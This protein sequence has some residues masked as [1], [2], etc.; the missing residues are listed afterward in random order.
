MAQLLFL[1]TFTHDGGL[2][3][4]CDLVQ[5]PTPVIVEEVRVI[6]LG[7][8][9]HVNMESGM[10]MRLGATLPTRFKLEF[11]A[12]DV[13]KPTASTF[14]SLGILP[15]DQNGQI[16]MNTGGRKIPTDGLVLRGLYSTIT[17]AVYGILTPTSAE[18]LALASTVKEEEPE[19]VPVATPAVAHHH[20]Q[21]HQHRGH[22]QSTKRNEWANT[23]P[24]T[25]SEND[26]GRTSV[27]HE[28]HHHHHNQGSNSRSWNSMENG[29]RSTL[30]NSYE[31]GSID[32]YNHRS[33]YHRARSRSPP[34]HR[35][36]TRSPPPP[37]PPPPVP[38]SG[39][40][41]RS[42]TPKSPQGN[43]GYNNT[44]PSTAEGSSNR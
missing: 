31:P 19:H 35:S 28:R 2:S 9:I 4:Q 18:Q 12:N 33:H 10:N 15:Y 30:E 24:S 6:P 34:R 26:T 25:V 22:H 37:L 23:W 5:F 29:Q 1:D 8:R 40:S 16:H 32:K 42:L 44:S 43:N 7:A 41:R 13:T 14:S 39:T 38:R 36:G 3:P 27:T 17:L 11:F 21:H 20:H